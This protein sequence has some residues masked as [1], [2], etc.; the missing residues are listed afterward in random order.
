MRFVLPGDKA[1]FEGYTPALRA[2][3]S[4]FR[5]AGL[6]INFLA[7]ASPTHGK[8]IHIRKNAKIIESL[9]LEGYSP[10]QAVKT[11]AAWVEL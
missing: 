5:K 9:S 1:V 10:A 3:E 11:V 6:G 7:D 2:L 4:S 8:K